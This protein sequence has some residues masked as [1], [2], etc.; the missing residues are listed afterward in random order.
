[1]PLGARFGDHGR[2]GPHM[3]GQDQTRGRAIGRRDFDCVG[4]PHKKLGPR[5]WQIIEIQHARYVAL[6]RLI[7]KDMVRVD[8][9]TRYVHSLL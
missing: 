4:F 6:D 2:S 3:G 7:R 8:A 1:M 5:C 9:E